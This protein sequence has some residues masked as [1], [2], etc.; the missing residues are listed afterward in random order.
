[1]YIIQLLNDLI[2]SII[3]DKYGVEN[4]EIT[5]TKPPEDINFD[6]AINVAFGLSKILKKNPVLIA[7]ELADELKKENKIKEINIEKGYINILLDNEF[8]KYEIFKII[9]DK[10][11]FKTNTGQNKKVNIEFVSANPVGPLNVVNGRAAAFGDTLANLL[12]YSG[13]DVHKEYYV[14]DFGRQV[15]LFG[16]S[17]EERYYELHKL[18]EKAEIP[19]DGYKGEYLINIAK[20]IDLDR[21]NTLEEVKNALE[22]KQLHD[23]E[24]FFKTYGINYVLNWQKTTLENFGVQFDEWFSEKSLYE[25]NEVENVLNILK[26]KNLIIEEDGALWF[27]TTIFGDDKKRVVK[28]ADGEFTYFAGDIAYMN[29]KFKRGF[30]IIINILGPDHHGYI[31][32]LEAIVKALGYNENCVKI[33]I[34]QQVNLLQKGEKLKMSKREGRLVLLDE[35]IDTVGKDA[36]RY[37]FVMRNPNSHLDFDIE[38]AREQSDKNPVYY[39]QYAYAR[40]CNI[41]NFATEKHIFVEDYDFQEIDFS[42]LEKEERRIITFLLDLP[43]YI[44]EAAKK[45]SPS[46]F[47]QKIYELVTIFHFFYNKYRVISNDDKITTLKRLL[48]MKALRISLYNCFK[49]IGITPK[50]NM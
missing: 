5:I 46:F 42:K 6:Y 15:K 12:K 35:L 31:K 1:M 20:Q 23:I 48:I 18:K 38:L 21:E 49:I 11:Y 7:N 2:K 45:F 13:F 32:R 25:N 22:L 28:K 43:A 33:I 10:T 16:K 50:E 34:L 4:C 27:D 3:K 17:I 30:D 24:D 29:N 39:I 26:E 44:D 37:Y 40:I 9:N 36:A 14:N 8:L 19:E 41:F 47:V